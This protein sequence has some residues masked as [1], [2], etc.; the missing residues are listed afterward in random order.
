MASTM[1]AAHETSAP[2]T[3]KMLGRYRIL[4][5]LAV[6][7]MAE[8]WLA[9]RTSISGAPGH[10]KDGGRDGGGD[11]HNVVLKTML[12]SVAESSEFVRMFLTE[13]AI[14]ARLKHPNL[15]RVID[16]GRLADRYFIAME[17]ID[18]LTLRQIGQRVQE[19]GQVFPQRLL[20]TVAVD[21]CRGLHTAHEL[22]DRGG[23][24][25]FVHRDV[26]PENIMV[27]R[28]GVTKLIDYGAAATLRIPPNTARFVGKFR[29]VAPERIEGRAEDRRVD[30]YSLGVILYEYLT[31]VRP[32]EGDDLAMVSRI[33]EG[34]P[35]SPVELVPGLEPELCRIVLKALALDPDDRYRT[36]ADLAAD[37]LPLMEGAGCVAAAEES[38]QLLRRIFASPTGEGEE[39]GSG[40]R[41][42]DDVETEAKT[43][44]MEVD[45]LKEVLRRTRDEITVV[46]RARAARNRTVVTEARQAATGRPVTARPGRPGSRGGG[47]PVAGIA[48]V[49]TPVPSDMNLD[50]ASPIATPPPSAGPPRWPTPIPLAAPPDA[51]DPDLPEAVASLPTLAPSASTAPTR[52][53]ATDV[54]PAPAA[55]VPLSPSW[56]FDRRDSMAAAGASGLFSDR[57][58]RETSGCF[59]I[60]R[61]DRRGEVPAG[62]EHDGRGAP[63]F[64]T[65]ALP[66]PFDRPSA[67]P[68]PRRHPPVPEAVRCFDR[69]LSLLQDKL[70]AAALAEWEK[71]VE[72]DGDNRMYQVNVK[73]LRERIVRSSLTQPE[74]WT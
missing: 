45:A 2:L 63:A 13:A 21:I 16:H 49:P 33:L 3:G 71:A 15:V 12:P 73:R 59:D 19:L 47:T 51:R 32:F 17:H 34:R 23:L 61:L 7:G 22:R 64:A 72:L 26:S 36:A 1:S 27:S 50:L 38:R 56:L 52:V 74:E 4:S 60:R 65:S 30:V 20:L 6:G 35:R 40:P 58:G 29:Y 69:G 39:S 48:P 25:H 54:A 53:V 9:L 10:A 37:L 70:Y 8:L 28:A 43:V 44:E 66:A 18:G 14:G 41:P 62:A 68:P 24:V 67:P 46:R 5:R 31:G 55:A 11:G 42:V 57:A